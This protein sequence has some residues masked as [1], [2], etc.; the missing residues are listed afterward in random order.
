MATE[1]PEAPVLLPEMWL[2]VEQVIVDGTRLFYRLGPALPL[3]D[4]LGRHRH[5][6]RGRVALEAF[7]ALPFAAMYGRLN[8]Y[9]ASLGDGA[10]ADAAGYRSAFRELVAFVEVFGPLGLEWSRMYLVENPE[11]DRLATE[12]ERLKLEALGIDQAQARRVGGLGTDVWRAGFFQ[13]GILRPGLVERVRTYPELPWDERVRLGDERVHHDDLGVVNGGLFSWVYGVV[14]DVLRLVEALA[15]ANPIEIR[16]ALSAMPRY[17]AFWVG[18]RRDDSALTLDWR[19]TIKGIAPSD[20]WFKPFMEHPTQVDWTGL[21]WRVLAEHFSYALSE[22]RM[23]V[24]LPDG[25]LR[26]GWR[27]GSL[28]EV[29]YLQLFDHVQRHPDFGIGRCDGCGAPILRV[30]R[31]QRWHSGCA[32]AGRQRESRAARKLRAQANQAPEGGS[33]A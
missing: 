32:P 11:A 6:D 12:N 8:S 25:K 31:Q 9:V 15:R 4:A 30:R 23:G 16:S 20:G 28:I 21:G 29:I 18:G 10:E 22:T 24:G 33:D 26:L 7:M 17:P 27:I 19:A 3:R 5:D 14:R 2:S 1:L 13:P